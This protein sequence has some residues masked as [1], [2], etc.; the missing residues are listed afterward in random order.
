MRQRRSHPILLPML[1]IAGLM[2]MVL[3]ALPGSQ[4]QSI[5]DIDQTGDISAQASAPRHS[6]FF[7]LLPRSLLP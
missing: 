4:P 7:S 5:A 3:S 1:A 6:N 2:L